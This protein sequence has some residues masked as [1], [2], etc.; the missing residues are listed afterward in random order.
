MSWNDGGSWPI[1]SKNR[2]LCWGFFA[3][4]IAAP[5]VAFPRTKT[6][7]EKTLLGEFVHI[8]DLRLF[9]EWGNLHTVEHCELCCCAMCVAVISIKRCNLFVDEAKSRMNNMVQHKLSWMSSLGNECR[10]FLRKQN[11]L[12]KAELQLW[13]T[14]KMVAAVIENSC[15]VLCKLIA[16]VEKQIC[17]AWMPLLRAMAWRQNRVGCEGGIAN[18]G[19]PCPPIVWRCAKNLKEKLAGRWSDQT[20]VAAPRC[21]SKRR[22]IALNLQSISK[23]LSWLWLPS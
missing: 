17:N 2:R 19:N 14:Q 23:L 11:V 4:R 10:L 21:T 22:A 15:I 18:N 12:H 5:A 7:W 1:L 3:S 20:Q 9:E 16:P 6:W 13:T 8:F